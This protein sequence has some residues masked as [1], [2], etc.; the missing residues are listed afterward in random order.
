MLPGIDTALYHAERGPQCKLFYVLCVQLHIIFG[1]ACLCG[2]SFP[3][4]Y[5]NKTC[6]TSKAKSA[7]CTQHDDL[8]GVKRLDIYS[9]STH[10]AE[11]SSSSGPLLGSLPRPEAS[12]PSSFTEYS[13]EETT[14]HPQTDFEEGS[15]HRET[16]IARVGIVDL[17]ASVAVGSAVGTVVAGTASC[18]MGTTTFALTLGLGS[19]GQYLGLAVGIAN[20]VVGLALVGAAATGGL[21]ACVWS[22]SSNGQ[23]KNWVDSN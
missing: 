2:N 10:N 18:A 13:T 3:A 21:V 6:A 11:A 1:G 5:S 22:P 20:P 12:G 17:S 8:A 23:Q 16:A 4:N 19:S 15:L 14:T 9:D 7:A